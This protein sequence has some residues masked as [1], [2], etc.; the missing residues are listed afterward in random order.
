MI[1][2]KL[3]LATQ[4]AIDP[5]SNTGSNSQTVST[6]D[7]K[8]VGDKVADG[9]QVHVDWLAGT[10]RY[11]DDKTR[12]EC[13]QFI[14]RYIGG[15]FHL[16]PGVP[17]H[18]GIVFAHSGRSING[19]RIAWNDPNGDADSLGHLYISLPGSPLSQMEVIDVWQLCCGLYDTWRFKATRFDVALD[20]YEKSISCDQMANAIK[21]GNKAKFG[22]KSELTRNLGE[23]GFTLYM[24]RPSSDRR[25]CFYNKAAE[26]NGELDCYRLE[27]RFKDELA[28]SVFKNWIGIESEQFEVLS[29]SYLAGCVTGAIDFPNRTSNPEE[30]NLSRLPRLNWWQALLDR[31]GSVV[32]HS[33]ARVVRSLDRTKK[34]IENQVLR[35]LVVVRETE[36]PPAYHSWMKEKMNQAKQNLSSWQQHWIREQ[37]QENL[38]RE[39]RVRDFVF[40]KAT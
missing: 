7:T 24:G 6:S 40:G 1:T 37:K 17:W 20:D 9:L 23:D 4:S 33:R 22:D 25:T 18:C 3:P 21:A 10:I 39:Q 34:W 19:A 11:S 31:V 5:P 27:T 30:K 35:S 38:I 8:R 12:Q 15:T 14:E 32:T 29:A 2:S 36:G 16:E 26:S 13:V 28:V